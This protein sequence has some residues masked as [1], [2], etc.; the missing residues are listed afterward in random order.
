M[1]VGPDAE[2]LTVVAEHRKRPVA[3]GGEAAE[4]IDRLFR[5]PEGD[6]IPEPLAHR[7]DRER[8]P[9]PLGEPVAVELILGKTGGLEVGVVEDRPLDPGAGEISGHAR[10][11]HPF[12]QPHAADPGVEAAL[13]PGGVAAD[14]ADPIAW[15]E[16]RQNRLVERP[17]DN[18][19]LA[20]VGQP[21]QPVE[22]LRVVGVEPLGERA[23]GVDGDADAGV[24]LEEIEERLVGILPGLFEDAIEVADRLMVVDH[25]DEPDGGGHAGPRRRRGPNRW[26]TALTPGGKASS[27]APGSIG[28]R[29]RFFQR[30]RQRGGASPSTVDGEAGERGAAAG[31]SIVDDRPPGL[32][33][34]PAGKASA[35]VGGAAL[36]SGQTARKRLADASGDIAEMWHP[37]P[38]SKP[39]RG[40]IRGRISRCHRQPG[41]TH[42]CGAIPPAPGSG[43]EGA[44]KGA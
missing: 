41:G 31:S 24:A 10:I 34:G 16:H 36:A 21:R 38:N 23:A 19:D 30:G 11:P 32:Q 25:E 44:R 35:R 27:G 1:G 13:E 33:T 3:S 26:R 5:G 6:D 29:H 7:E 2:L 8:R 18:L 12:R 42:P 37:I 22:I 40:E 39:A 20:F 4:M 14:L 17:A 28:R 43:P 15:R 9:V